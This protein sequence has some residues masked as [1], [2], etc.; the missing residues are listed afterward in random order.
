MVSA[1]VSH[2]RFLPWVLVLASLDDGLYP[3]SQI[4]LFLRKVFLV[5]VLPQQPRNKLGQWLC[6]FFS[7]S[8]THLFVSIIASEKSALS[9]LVFLCMQC[10]FPVAY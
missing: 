4:D 3:V 1:S 7:I 9:M 10:L 6:L 5:S 8:K 2:S